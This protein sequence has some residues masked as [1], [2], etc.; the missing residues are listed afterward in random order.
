MGSNQF[1]LTGLSDS[2]NAVLFYDKHGIQARLAYNWRDRFLA[3]YGLDPSY[4]E[5]YGQVDASAS[6]EFRKG[7]IAFA[8][9]I[10]LT[11][12]SRRGYSR[13]RNNVTFVIPGAARYSAGLRYTF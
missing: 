12:G 5:P 1:A 3:G 10:N 2:A 13:T 11:G 7:W 6:Y 8:E 9:G 4:V